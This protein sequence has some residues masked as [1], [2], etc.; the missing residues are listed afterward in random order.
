[1]RRT[2][3]ISQRIDWLTAS[4]VLALMLI[5]LF[6]VASATADA[7]TIEWFDFSGKLGKQ[8]LWVGA[9][10]I[11]AFLL[12]VIEGEF[13]IRTSIIHYTLNVLLLIAVLVV[14]KRIG[15][16][17]SWFSIGSIG[18]QPSEFAKT[19]TSLMLAW[20]LSRN[21][22]RFNQWESLFKAVAIVSLPAALVLLQPDAGTV[23]VFTGLILVFYREGLSGNVLIAVLCALLITIATIL[24]GASTIQYPGGFESTGAWILWVILISIGIFLWATVPE[25]TVPR[26]RKRTR[27]T[28]L[29]SF[30]ATIILSVGLQF[31]LEEVLR[32]HQ[33]D[34]IHVLFGID[35]G[36]PDADYNIRHAKAAISSGGFAG[37]G[38]LKGPMTAYGFVPE[39]ETDFIFCTIAEEWGLIGT[40]ATVLFFTLLLL[41]ILTLAERQRS[42]FTRIYAYAVAS[43]LFM[44]YAINVGMVLGL[45][46]VIGIPLPFISAGGSSLTGFTMLVFILLRLDAERFTVLR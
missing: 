8:L 6:N 16:A 29:F 42:D 26:R 31:G 13:F 32:P 17:K 18:I 4:F 45:A 27:R 3:P 19:G 41:R 12:L 9:S 33:R 34:R 23:L 20:I 22:D 14:G 11:L 40:S 35:V 44:H 24:S 5:G 25:W 36:N 43:I 7:S 10:L 30:A 46:P 2:A 1:M 15:G 38:F 28:V 39:Q 37:K 21:Q